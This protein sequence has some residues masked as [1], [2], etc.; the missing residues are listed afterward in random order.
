MRIIGAS[1]LAA[2]L[3]LV[4]ATPTLAAKKATVKVI[5]Q[6]DWS[7]NH[8]FLSPA[9][10]ESWGPDWLGE[11]VMEKGDSMKL[12]GISCGDYDI[13]VVDEDGDECIIAAVELC[14]D[15]SEWKITNKELLSCIADE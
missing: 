10:E 4:T 7:I 13:R 8:L 15:D 9:D 6:S 14:G 11:D 5:N 2:G 1:L 12:T 3:L